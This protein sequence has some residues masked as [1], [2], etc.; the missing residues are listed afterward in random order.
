MKNYKVKERADS[1]NAAGSM[2]LFVLFAVCTLMMIVTAA[3]TY[4]RISGD[5]DGIFGGS[6][7]LR[8]VSNKIR[9]ADRTEIIGG[10]NGIA[11]ESGGVMSVIY[12]DD[13]E[14]YERTAAA[15]ERPEMSGGEP[16]FSLDSM[17]ISDEGGLYRITVSLNGEDYSVL[18]REG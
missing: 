12:F 4:T 14:L 13:G 9:S 2:L 10:G 5:F 18:V 6:A 11:A 16:I 15:G 1:A 3:G 8:Y 17:E 7:A